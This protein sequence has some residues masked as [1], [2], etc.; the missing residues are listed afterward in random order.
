MPLLI[1]VCGTAAIVAA[2][3]VATGDARLSGLWIAALLASL[4][5]LENGARRSVM[6]WGREAQTISCEELAV[7]AAPLVASPAAI[8]VSVAVASLLTNL[9]LRRPRIKA[10]WNVA[11]LTFQA[12]VAMIV[13]VELGGARDGSTRSLFAALAAAVAFLVV[14]IGLFSLLLNRLGAGPLR[15]TLAGTVRGEAAHT[16]GILSIGVLGA[17]AL[18]RDAWTLPFVL[19]AVVAFERGLDG[20]IRAR[21]NHNRVESLLAASSDGIFALDGNGRITSWNPAME[22]LLAVDAASAVGRP[23]RAVAAGILTDGQIDLLL[24]NGT[25]PLELGIVDSL[26]ERRT[27]RVARSPIPASG[28]ILTV[29]DSTA[30]VSSLE[31]VRAN[32]DR[33]GLALKSSGAALWEWDP[34]EGRFTWSENLGSG[35]GSGPQAFAA[36][37]GLLAEDVSRAERANEAALASGEPYE[38]EVRAAGQDGVRWLRLRADVIRRNGTTLLRGITLDIS[39]TRRREEERRELAKATRIASSQAADAEQRLQRMLEQMNDGFYAI[40]RDWR[41][42]YVNERGARLLGSTPGELVGGSPAAYERL[43]SVFAS[44]CRESME[45]RVVTRVEDEALEP[46]RWFEL[47]VHPAPEGIW[48]FTRETTEERHLE[49]QLRHAQKMDAVG[50]L[51]GGIAH[52]F[53]N[54]LTVINGYSSLALA[55]A[56]QVD[57][58]LARRVEQVLAAGQRAAALTSQL[59][60]F[61]RQQVLQTRVV[62]LN[63]AVADVE[64][65]LRRVIGPRI[66]IE[67]SLHPHLHDVK[68]DPGGLEQ[69]LMNL[70]V[71]ARDAINGDPGTITIQTANRT[72]EPGD[73]LPDPELRP[74]DYVVVSVGDTGSGIPEDILPRIFEPFFTTKPAGSGTGLGLATA[75]GIVKQSGGALTVSSG[76]EGTVFTVLLPRT[77]E[78][79]AALA[80]EI[81][82]PAG[83]G[84][85]ILLVEDEPVV[86][87]LTREL[88]TSFGY[89]VV[90]VDSAEAAL[91][92]SADYDLLVS[93]VVMPGKNGIELASEL[94]GARP[95]LRVLLVSGHSTDDMRLLDGNRR[96]RY[97]SKPFTPHDLAWTVRSL[98]DAPPETDSGRFLASPTMV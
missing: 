7:V 62:D 19:L 42:A 39:E 44:A 61:S 53:N 64:G 6:R 77:F 5:I 13:F 88:L 57:G 55:R 36:G 87:G 22:L 51:A 35:G 9:L 16:V 3:C 34:A 11:S 32:R 83:G 40:D 78:R 52:D 82:A 69:V 89:R 72:Y 33:L 30:L 90:D 98:L 1:V 2:A 48:L 94:T 28:T 14:N 75:Y 71:N 74:G 56:T 92:V 25:D 10:V 65:M 93:D 8:V 91:A 45:H 23:L 15:E 58:L 18:V 49:E 63:A 27:L 59:L 50:R 80:P 97:L 76:S 21:E 46:G 41:F 73:V 60:A 37:L 85:S 31:A 95:G 47:T 67:T 70:C 17:L 66:S 20:Y 29:S 4:G 86:R 54:L 24:D 96:W 68:A 81:D 38:I 12:L 84:E 79:V 26:G 43:G